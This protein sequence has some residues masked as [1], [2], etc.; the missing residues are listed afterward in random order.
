MVEK[1]GIY[2]HPNV[3][4][5]DHINRCIE[6]LDFYI[7]QNNLTKDDDD[8]LKTIKT[9]LALHDFGKF[10]TYFQ[11]HIKN[12]SINSKDKTLKKLKEHSLL[13]GIYAYYCLKKFVDN[14]TYQAFAFIACKRHHTNPKSFSYEF[15][16]KDVDIIKRQIETIEEN[17]FNIFVKNLHLDDN[18]KDH[19]RFDKESFDA[20]IDKTIEEIKHL[21]INFI[22]DNF[23]EEEKNTLTD[24]IKFQYIYSLILDADKTEAGAKPFIPK[25]INDITPQVVLDYK[26]KLYKSKSEKDINKLREQAFEYVLSKSLDTSNKIYSITLPTGMGK[27]LI[28]FSFALKLREEIKQLTNTIPR[29]IY[30]LPFVSIIDQNAEVFEQVL[31]SKFNNVS[32]NI[33]LKHHHLSDPKYNSDIN[34]ESEFDFSVSR[35]L[36]EGWNSE[37]IVTTFV[38]LFNTVVS[39]LSSSSRRF[40]KL[41]NAIVIID[42]VQALRPEYWKLV[43]DMVK[44]LSNT[45]N[46]YFIFM[47]ATQPYLV[48]DAIELA[49]KEK[50]LDKLNRYNVYVD[51]KDKSINEF[52]KD[53]DIDD[54]KTYLFITNT[55]A[56]SKELYK[57]LKEKVNEP[58]GYLSTAITPYERKIRIKDIKEGKFRLVV[59]TQLVEAGVDIDFDV[60]YR[61][62]APLDSLNQS[63]GRCNRNMEKTGEFRVIKLVSEKGQQ[64]SKL[65]YDNLL[66]NLTENILKDKNMLSE[67]EFIKLIEEYFKELRKRMSDDISND[68]IEA[69]KLFKFDKTGDRKISI[70]D[71]VLIEEDKYKQNVFI[72]IND[73]AKDAWNQAKDIIKRLKDK[74][75]NVFEAKE[76]FEKLKS[77]FF[78]YV[79]HVN[80]QDNQPRLD[81]ELKMYIVSQEELDDYYDRETGFG[82]QFR[83][84][85]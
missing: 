5:E 16:I 75:I 24:F 43:S 74:K 13:S 67:K 64:Y 76:E 30:A 40:N 84:I 54:N 11:D 60:V 47:T 77:V 56:S 42:E 35:V 71:F 69:I 45:L 22:G 12:G 61:D 52:I 10:T 62:F 26:D 57:L 7:Q 65:I 68:I 53:L 31:K 6:L 41:S 80:V 55:I 49:N 58:I 18:I 73:E 70:S 32:S 14:K 82:K 81:E 85:Y 19:I 83:I 34:N 8:F 17:K 78:E 20:D 1:S 28:G 79:I 3:F 37:I 66:L 33:L 29:I 4:I 63:A 38:Q 23:G 48:E 39:Y 27:T 50:Y 44:E 36:M 9:T 72:E 51:L 21:E 59:S 25:R 2:S 46:T 15:D